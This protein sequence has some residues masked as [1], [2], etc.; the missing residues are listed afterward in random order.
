MN[1]S[2]RVKGFIHCRTCTLG[3]QTQR[4][5]VGV[6]DESLIV[7]CR[8]HGLVGEWSPHDLALLL[9][10]PPECECCRHGGPPS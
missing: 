3:G 7:L 8:K 9:A 4:L 5:E 2:A 10:H 1:H 6:T